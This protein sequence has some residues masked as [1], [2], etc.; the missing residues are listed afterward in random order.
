MY[1]VLR[2]SHELYGE[3]VLI[4][5]E[6]IGDYLSPFQAANRAKLLRRFSLE[7]GIVKINLL[8][9]NEI[10][11]VQDLEIWAKQEYDF[12]PKCR[13]C[14]C[15]LQ[16]QVYTHPLCKNSLFCSQL[17]ADKDYTSENEKM[18]DEV[19]IDYL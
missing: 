11:T 14:S 19:E 13:T 10:L 15:I 17:C 7:K 4:S 16:V 5:I 18:L 9:N 1:N 12:L 3:I 6:E 2:K 8:V